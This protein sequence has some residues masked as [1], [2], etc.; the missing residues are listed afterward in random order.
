MY[1]NNW[2]SDLYEILSEFGLE[3]T[4]DAMSIIN[5]KYF[6]ELMLHR[7]AKTWTDTISFKPKLRTYT[8]FKKDFGTE[9][10]LTGFMSRQQR[11]LLA[12]FRG[13]ILPLHVETGQWQNVAWEDRLCKLCNQNCVED[14]FHFLCIC[15]LYNHQRISLFEKV[16]KF[17]YLL[18][19]ENKEVAKY[20]EF[21]YNIRKICIY[22]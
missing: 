1:Y 8:K 13:G 11:S 3:Y 5:I 4:F 18:K 9:E 6:E 10:Y 12:K 22:S 14:E 20:L 16:D 19:F 17:I 15:E 2:S 21:A 7:T